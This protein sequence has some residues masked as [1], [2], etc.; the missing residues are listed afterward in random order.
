MVGTGYIRYPT[1]HYTRGVQAMRLGFQ[2]WVRSGEPGRG[3]VLRRPFSVVGRYTASF[4]IRVCLPESVHLSP[5]TTLGEDASTGWSVEKIAREPEDVFVC[6]FQRWR[7]NL[8]VRGR[9]RGCG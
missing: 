6:L 2:G 5:C 3:L 7:V 8:G 1:P 4:G 9:M